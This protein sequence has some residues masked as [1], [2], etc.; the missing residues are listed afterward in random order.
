MWKSWWH[1]WVAPHWRIGFLQNTLEEVIAGA[2]PEIKWMRAKHQDGWFADPFVLKV[3]DSSISLL[4]EEF[5]Y[6]TGKGRIVRLDID[7]ETLTLEKVTPLIDGCHLSFPFIIGSLPTE[8]SEA[9]GSKFKVQGSKPSG[10]SMLPTEGGRPP[11]PGSRFQVQGLPTDLHRFSQI[12]NDSSRQAIIFNPQF[13]IAFGDDCHDSVNQASLLTLAAPIILNSHEV[14]VFPETGKEG[15]WGC[16]RLNVD[17]NECVLERVMCDKP[18]VDA[19]IYEDHVFA[20]SFPDSN[21]KSLGVYEIYENGFQLVRNITFDENVAR[22]AGA[23]FKIG[24][25]VYRPAQEC[26]EWYGHALS[27]QEYQQG[28]FHEV[29]RIPGL[30]TLNM[31]QGV[32]VVDQKMFPRQWIY[33]LIGK[34]DL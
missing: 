12:I 3:T 28:T 20:T 1:R 34:S 26:N 6:K 10:L 14:M 24:D 32:T 7:R 15:R 22:N 25:K 21:G 2:E 5:R 16:Y 27:I 23:F 8:G 30:H 33:R 4:A 29:R 9:A 11:V 17:T 13:S 31:F 18:L 19:V